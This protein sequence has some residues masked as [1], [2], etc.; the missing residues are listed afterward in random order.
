MRQDAIRAIQELTGRRLLIYYSDGAPI[1]HDD[2][3]PFSDL[4]TDLPADSKVDLM[5]HSQ[6]GYA[7][8]AEKI[9]NLLNSKTSGVRMIVPE[10]AKSA[11]TLI[12]LGCNS[13]V[14][15]LTSELGPVDTQITLT[16]P[17]QSKYQVAARA[18]LNQF[19]TIVDEIAQ[20]NAKLQSYFQVLQGVDP[21]FI[22]YCEQAADQTVAFARKW[23]VKGMGIDDNNAEQIAK[24][25]S[26]PKEWVSHGHVIDAEEAG[27]IGLKIE[28]LD[29]GDELWQH[30]WYLHCSYRVALQQNQHR[31][32]KLFESERVSLP[33]N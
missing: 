17:N 13:I 24:R 29:D 22:A 18:W 12:A 16:G 14:M 26:D 32:S 7:E 27:N 3:P 5:M 33:G 1:H 6:G 15:G 11:A 30:I 19:R 10:M 28:K 20:D 8:A 2:I 9:I 31:F 4:L 23:L 21:G 25:L